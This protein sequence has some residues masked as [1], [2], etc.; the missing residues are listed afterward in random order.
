MSHFYRILLF[1]ILLLLP[2]SS[3]CQTNGEWLVEMNPEDGSF[4]PLGPMMTD[5]YTI[6]GGIHCKD[7]VNGQY[8][9]MRADNPIGFVS[10]DITNGEIVLQTPHPLGFITNLWG[11]YCYENCDSLLLILQDPDASYNTYFAFLDR[12]NGTEL[13]QFGDTIPNEA[14][15]M[16][17]VSKVYHSFD[18]IN[19]HLYLY[20]EEASLLRIMEVPSG[21]IIHTYSTELSP[22]FISFDEVNHKLYALENTEPYTYRLMV[23]VSGLNEFVQ[24]GSTFTS[25]SY[26]YDSHT[27]DGN[28]QRLFV[29]RNTAGNPSFMMSIDLNTGELLTDVQTMPED[30]NS[31][32]FGGP[33]VIHGEYFNSTDQLIALHWGDGTRITSVS[34]LTAS[35]KDVQI[36][37]NPNHG[38]FKF[39]FDENTGESYNL[40]I[41]NTKGQIVYKKADLKRDHLL[42]LDL[43]S[44]YYI[45]NVIIEDGVVF[46]RIPFIIN[47]G[48]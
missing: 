2:F 13:M 20:S 41:L 37:P 43:A 27:I 28:N 21:E 36:F 11:F 18:R 35:K 9:F 16:W 19:N 33:N 12:F 29:T 1:Q 39:D 8:I 32:L 44:G 24:L 14:T 42:N 38:A 10:V 26:G 7:E 45:A 5:I 23:F 48:K 3:F 15:D 34:S 6:F 22:M 46:E 40:T 31:G 25:S 47:S 17:N 4:E 30:P